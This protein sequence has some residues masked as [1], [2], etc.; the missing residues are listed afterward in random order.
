MNMHSKLVNA[1]MAAASCRLAATQTAQVTRG[2]AVVE[3]DDAGGLYRSDV[4]GVRSTKGL[5]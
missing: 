1:G 4:A 2:H 5:A 3:A